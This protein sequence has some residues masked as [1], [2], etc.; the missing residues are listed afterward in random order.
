MRVTCIKS[1]AVTAMVAK[2]PTPTATR[3]ARQP[4]PPVSPEALRL[5]TVGAGMLRSCVATPALDGETVARKAHWGLAM[6]SLALAQDPALTRG[7]RRQNRRDKGTIDLILAL[8]HAVPGT[9]RDWVGGPTTNATAETEG[10]ATELADLGGFPSTEAREEMFT[11]LG[12]LLEQASTR[13]GCVE[14]ARELADEQAD[15]ATYKLGHFLAELL[16]EIQAGTFQG[17]GWL[18]YQAPPRRRPAGTE[19]PAATSTE[20]T[21]EIAQ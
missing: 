16:T 18:T 17:V 12:I 5:I 7:L 19:T 1:E 4:L 10:E 11:R 6:I 13:P 9:L 20:T 3:R 21:R 8:G 15:D 14:R 2:T